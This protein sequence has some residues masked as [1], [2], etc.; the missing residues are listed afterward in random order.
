MGQRH[1]HVLTNSQV[2]WVKQ[3]AFWGLQVTGESIKTQ[4]PP[5]LSL[6]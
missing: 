6:C 2:L 4:Q 1:V 5:L 3:L